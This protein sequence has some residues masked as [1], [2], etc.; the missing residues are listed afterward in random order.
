MKILLFSLIFV[1]GL[2]SW[3]LVVANPV[4]D[5]CPDSHRVSY[6]FNIEFEEN[7]FLVGLEP[8]GKCDPEKIAKEI[9][10]CYDIPDKCL[11]YMCAWDKTNL[12]IP[13]CCDSHP[14]TC[15]Q[16][17]DLQELLAEKYCEN[18]VK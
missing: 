18:C 12:A 15:K 2:L 3:N 17:K 9:D 8:K 11:A 16:L 6:G 14:E 10:E 5:F 1:I 7:N 4:Q 13:K